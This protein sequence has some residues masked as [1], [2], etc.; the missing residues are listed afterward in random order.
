LQAVVAVVETPSGQER[1]SWSSPRSLRAT[2]VRRHEP[3]AD[4][5]GRRGAQYPAYFFGTEKALYDAV[6]AR[7]IARAQ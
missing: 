2:R 7:V 1:R 3:A 5:G 6:L 4:R